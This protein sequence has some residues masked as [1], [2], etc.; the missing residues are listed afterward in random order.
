MNYFHITIILCIIYTIACAIVNIP[1]INKHIPSGYEGFMWI[2]SL[3]LLGLVYM[4]SEPSLPAHSKRASSNDIG[5]IKLYE[6]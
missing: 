1:F 3:V 2:G 5:K 4:F 6:S